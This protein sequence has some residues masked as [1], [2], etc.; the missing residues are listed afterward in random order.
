MERLLRGLTKFQSQVF[1]ERREFY[2]RLATSQNPDVLFVTCGD[3]RIDPELLTQSG[4][5]EVFVER[6]PGNLVPVYDEQAQGGVSASIEYALV[7]LQV[8]NVV[9]CGHSDCGAMRGLLHPETLEAL[10]AVARWLTYG[11]TEPPKGTEEDRMRA[12]TRRNVLQ[13]MENLKTHP[14]ATERLAAGRL[15][16]YGWVYEIHTGQVETFDPATGLFAPYCFDRLS[17]AASVAK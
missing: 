11:A 17:G 16:V 3:S 1:P 8:R 4:P 2:E 6:N 13:Q 9:I 10:P 7:A 14:C 15:A 12:I 5:G